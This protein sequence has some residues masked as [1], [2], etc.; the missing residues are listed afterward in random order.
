MK[1]IQTFKY[2]IKDSNSAKILNKMAGA[3]N[4]VW[5]Y[6]NEVSKKSITYNSKWL[7]E[8]DLNNLTASCSKE[9]GISSVTVQSV[10]KE[11]VVRRVK[12]RKVKLA[13]RSKVRSL[14]WIPTKANAIS[15]HK[16]TVTYAGHTFRFW[17]SRELFG[18]IK[19]AN[20]SQDANGRWYMNIQCEV[21]KYL[22]QKTGKEIGIDLGLKTI[23]C[24]SDGNKYDREN[25]TKQ[26]EDK[27]AMAQRA[28]KK[29]LVRSIH[30]KIRNSRS[31]WAHKTTTE[32][33][34]SYDNIVVGNVSSSKLIKT[35]FAKSV[36]DAGWCQFK[37]LLAYKAIRFGKDFKEVNESFSTVTCSVCLNKT[38]ASGLS[39]LGV[40]EWTCSVCGCHHDR[41]TNAAQNI[42]RMGH[43]APKGIPLLQ[44]GEDVKLAR[45]LQKYTNKMQN[46]K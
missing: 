44:L 40:R 32:I 28:R 13:W 9:L 39:A 2:R 26:F 37:S 45:Q 3:V 17:K 33:V 19:T 7:S 18:K 31:D 38:G 43:H 8:Y 27:L 23:A 15:M 11:Y 4:F 1:I 5:N 35:N 12:A 34:K 21:E 20:F 25:L 6:C 16:D 36:S 10:C 41:D 46:Q 30:A 14:G 42:L 24:D 29:K 22:L